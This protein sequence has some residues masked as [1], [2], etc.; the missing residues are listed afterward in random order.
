[1]PVRYFPFLDRKDSW[2]YD[3]VTAG[4]DA[5]IVGESEIQGQVQRAVHHHQVMLEAGPRRPLI[6]DADTGRQLAFDHFAGEATRG[7]RDRPAREAGFGIVPYRLAAAPDE[8]HEG[9]FGHHHEARDGQSI[10]G[11]E[12]AQY[13]CR[14][15][16]LRILEPGECRPADAAAPCQ[17]VKRP[18]AP[19]AQPAQTL[20]D[21]MI[22]VGGKSG[23]A[24]HI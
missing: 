15:A 18:A 8:R 6:G 14:C 11:A 21:A 24:S 20:G 23:F 7:W 13:R 4:L 1:M 3:A 19:A 22:D 9:V 16:D 12:L 10:G 17:L 5:M 2:T